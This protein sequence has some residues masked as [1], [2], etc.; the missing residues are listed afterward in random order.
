M[1]FFTW[2]LDL[3]RQLAGLILPIFAQAADFKKLGPA[4]RWALRLLLLGLILVVAWYIGSRTDFWRNLGY[5]PQGVPKGVLDFYLPSLVLMTFLFLGLA[6]WLWTLLWPKKQPS[7]FPDIDEAWEQGCR[8]LAEAGLDLH[9]LPLFLILGKA[10]GGEKA[11]FAAAQIKLALDGTPRAPEQPVHLYAST[12]Q[13]ER[14][15]TLGIY[16]TCPG[17][18]LLGQEPELASASG[19]GGPGRVDPHATL[20]PN[21]MTNEEFRNLFERNQKGQ[22]TAAEKQR[23]QEL[24]AQDPTLISGSGL[25][26]SWRPLLENAEELERHVR[27]LK[28]LCGLIARDRRPYYP[29][30]GMLVLLPAGATENEAEANAV[31]QL[32]RR[33]LNAAHEALQMQFPV[34]ALVC[35]MERVPGFQELIQQLPTEVR[36]RRVGQ[37]IPI[38]LDRPPVEIPETLRW[39]ARGI[40]HSVFANRVYELFRLESPRTPGTRET[41]LRTNVQLYRL[42][43]NMCQREPHLGH[44][45]ARGL[46]VEADDPRFLGGCYLAATGSD[47]G[48]EQAFVAGVFRRLPEEQGRV[49][50]DRRGRDEEARYE[51]WTRYGYLALTVCIVLGLVL[52]AGYLWW[53]LAS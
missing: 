4:L 22:S 13:S 48:A 3:L 1:G 41:T 43:Q 23:L 52:L 9:R 29:I 2:I 27:R 8:G 37:R 51:R 32:C 6:W 50:W 19:Q 39:L 14:D 25:S 10:E 28:H 24:I 12:E 26:R 33:D 49:R 18:C 34:F 16:I 30:N 42:L 15:D 7:E 20:G 44:L 21:V 40:T 45:Y 35:D 17:A 31:G 47:G 38:L 53:W 11:L 5:A 36:Q 46:T